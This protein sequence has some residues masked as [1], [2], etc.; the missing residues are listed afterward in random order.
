MT[1]TIAFLMLMAG[2][3]R[4]AISPP[5]PAAR[6]PTVRDGAQRF[7]ASVFFGS[8][9]IGSLRPLR[10]LEDAVRLDPDAV[11]PR[12][13][14]IPLY[15]AVG[16]QN[17]AASDAAVG[18]HHR[19]FAGRHLADARPPAR[20]TEA[21]RRRHLGPQSLRGRGGTGRSAGRS[22]RR[23]PRSGSA[24]F[25]SWRTSA[26]GRCLSQ[27]TRVCSPSSRA[28]LLKN[29][30]PVELDRERRNCWI[31][32]PPRIL[33]PAN[34]PRRGMPRS[35]RVPDFASVNDS[36]RHGRPVVNAGRRLR[37]SRRCRQGPRIARRLPPRPA[38]RRGR[39]RPEG[40]IAPRS[41]RW[42]DRSRPC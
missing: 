25:G 13:L 4:P 32:W 12:Q 21:D 29:A 8:G 40:S 9:R 34:S 30:G 14:L 39:V 7:M 20:R 41:R 31:R 22:D 38:A 3:D 17:D 6:A 16:R 42:P 26:S 18:G 33:L 15:A 5:D 28:T 1:A 10:C 35:K 27:G 19:P 36:S 23:L 11:P 2:Q 24:V 37:R